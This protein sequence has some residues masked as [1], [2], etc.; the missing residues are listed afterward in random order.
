MLAEAAHAILTEAGTVLHGAERRGGFVELHAVNAGVDLQADDGLQIFAPDRVVAVHV[1]AVL[2]AVGRFDPTGMVGAAV[3]PARGAFLEQIGDGLTGAVGQAVREIVREALPQL[4]IAV[5]GEL[6]QAEFGLLA[7]PAQ[8]VEGEDFALVVVQL[9][10]EL[11]ALRFEDDPEHGDAALAA[12]CNELAI[13]ERT[14]HAVTRRD[15]AVDLLLEVGKRDRPAA[16]RGPDEHGAA[17]ALD[18]F[19]LRESP[20]R[21]ARM[22]AVMAAMPSVEVD[23]ALQGEPLPTILFSNVDRSQL[24]KSR[25]TRQSGL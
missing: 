8:L 10:A 13:G 2:R 9:D 19:D 12:L 22:V 6:T 7:D 1:V 24:D 20:R 23:A 14:I 3:E 16:K 18:V 5:L 21:Q 25:Q 11:P 4:R 17:V 15:R